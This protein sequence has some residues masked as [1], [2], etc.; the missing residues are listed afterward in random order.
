MAPYHQHLFNG[1]IDPAAGGSKNTFTYSDSVQMPWDKRLNPMGI[2]YTSQQ[3]TAYRAGH[4]KDNVQDGC[5]F[6]I[7]NENVQNLV[8]LTPNWVQDCA[9]SIA[10]K[11]SA[12][13]TCLRP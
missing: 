11:L 8:S 7:V 6:K 2:G 9:N 13:V 12:S 1:R 3:N 4:V 10:G 5:V